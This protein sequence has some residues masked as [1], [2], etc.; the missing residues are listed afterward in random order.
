LKFQRYDGADVF[1]SPLVSF[2]GD[3]PVSFDRAPC[4]CEKPLSRAEHV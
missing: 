2:A 1:S 4:A 3:A